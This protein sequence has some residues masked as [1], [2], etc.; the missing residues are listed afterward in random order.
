MWKESTFVL[1]KVFKTTEVTNPRHT[2]KT[3]TQRM[4]SELLFEWKFMKIPMNVIYSLNKTS[5]KF[6]L[7][8]YVHAF[9]YEVLKSAKISHFQS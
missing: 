8:N 5:I 3:V 6:L 9:R 1:K 4:L 2:Y 7:Q